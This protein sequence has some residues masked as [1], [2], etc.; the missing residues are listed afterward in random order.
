MIQGVPGMIQGV[1]G[2]MNQGP[3]EASRMNQ[4][5]VSRPDLGVRTSLEAGSRSQDQT[6]LGIS[7]LMT[8]E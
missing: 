7:T 1:P 4:G 5:P 3:V 6:D 8:K 2:M